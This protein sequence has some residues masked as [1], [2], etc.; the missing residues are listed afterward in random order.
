LNDLGVQQKKFE[1][2]VPY[3]LKIYSRLGYYD[4]SLGEFPDPDPPKKLPKNFKLD[5]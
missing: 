2:V 1:D 5:L 3:H 4:Q